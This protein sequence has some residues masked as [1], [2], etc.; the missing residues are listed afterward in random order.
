MPIHACQ[1]LYFASIHHPQA[2]IFLTFHNGFPIIRFSYAMAIR[3]AL[4]MKRSALWPAADA[5]SPAKIS[6][7]SDDFSSVIPSSLLRGASF[8]DTDVPPFNIDVKDPP[9][10]QLEISACMPH[11]DFHH[12]KGGRITPAVP[13]VALTAPTAK[14]H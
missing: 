10:L 7:S 9:A 3:S 13:T 14:S 6:G 5:E 8:Q 2:E 1:H 4:I 12:R 11:P